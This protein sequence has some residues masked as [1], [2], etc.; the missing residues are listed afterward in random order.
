MI[1]HKGWIR[2]N[3]YTDIEI[4]QQYLAKLEDSYHVTKETIERMVGLKAETLS[5]YL[6]EERTLTSDE[7]QRLGTVCEILLNGVTGVNDDNR[8]RGVLDHLVE[9][10]SIS[11]ETLSLFSNVAAE[12]IKQFREG[13]EALSDDKKYRLSVKAYYLLLIASQNRL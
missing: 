12:D 8:I 1:P 3:T 7:Q 10:F 13:E 11:Y 5:A 6:R 4:I 2:M 9:D